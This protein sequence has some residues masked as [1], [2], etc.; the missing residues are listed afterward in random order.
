MPAVLL[1]LQGQATVTLV[2]DRHQAVAGTWVY[3]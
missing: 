2:D 3:C 1:F